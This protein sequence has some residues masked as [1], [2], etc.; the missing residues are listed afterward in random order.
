MPIF[1]IPGIRNI[2]VRTNYP[3]S[4]PVLVEYVVKRALHYVLV[5]P[6]SYK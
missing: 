1:P 4:V 2:Y 6:R 3:S 5:G